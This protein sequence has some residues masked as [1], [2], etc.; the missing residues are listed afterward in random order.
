MN[1]NN[2]HLV[3]VCDLI[4]AGAF[5]ISGTYYAFA[6]CA[7]GLVSSGLILL[8]EYWDNKKKKG[9]VNEPAK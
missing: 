4:L 7:G 5:L 3:M 1:N 9:D 8:F 2:I 6:A